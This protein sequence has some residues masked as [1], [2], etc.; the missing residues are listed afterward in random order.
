MN[1]FG[2]SIECVCVWRVGAQSP[3]AEKNS[4]TLKNPLARKIWVRP[5]KGL[6]GSLW[7]WGG[8]RKPDPEW[9]LLALSPGA[10]ALSGGQCL[11]PCKPPLSILH[12][13]LGVRLPAAQGGDYYGFPNEQTGT[14][15]REVKGWLHATQLA[16]EA[17]AQSWG[18]RLPSPLPCP[19]CFSGFWVV[20]KRAGELEFLA[21]VTDSQQ[22]SEGR[23]GGHQAS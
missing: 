8:G 14:R 18:S 5:E 12:S 10:S 22:P 7:G 9:V 21:C 23:A 4:L 1:T 6:C 11:A 13:T 3:F 19:Q 17:G 16:A 20:R 2:K 15:A